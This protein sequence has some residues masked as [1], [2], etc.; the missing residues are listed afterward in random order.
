M[1]L[2]CDTFESFMFVFASDLARSSLRLYSLHKVGVKQSIINE[3]SVFV[4]VFKIT[5]PSKSMN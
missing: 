2:Y 3:I 4:T 1:P 5:G